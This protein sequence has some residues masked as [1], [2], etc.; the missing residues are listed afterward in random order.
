MAQ[1][2][3]HISKYVTYGECIAS[4]TADKLNIKNIPPIHLLDN[5]TKVATNCF[6][7][8]RI[9]IG[10]PLGINSF[11]RCKALNDSLGSTDKSHHLLGMAID[12]DAT[13]YSS[14]TKHPWTNAMLFTW[15]AI[16]LKY[17]QI[18][19]EGE[20][21]DGEP[22]WVHIAYDENNLIQK[23]TMYTRRTGYVNFNLDMA[24][25]ESDLNSKLKSFI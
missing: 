1:S 14:S 25:L 20:R 11:Y 2:T 21:S 13:K 22:Q 16:N 15:M 8:A 17:T 3:D 18:I 10:Y 4:P 6:D 12:C 5:M 24:K 7:P 19:W 23:K 9:K